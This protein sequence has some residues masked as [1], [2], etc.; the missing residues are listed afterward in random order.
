[1]EKQTIDKP[2]TVV[3]RNIRLTGELMRYLMDQPQ[4]FRTLPDHFEVVL[5]PDDDPEQHEWNTIQEALDDT[6]YRDI[7]YVYNNIY[8][9]DIVIDKSISLIELKI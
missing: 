1:M 7:I 6:S 5:L 9:E 3:D 8:Y 4:V 2:G